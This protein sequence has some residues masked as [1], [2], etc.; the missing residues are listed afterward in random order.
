MGTMMMYILTIKSIRKDTILTMKMKTM[1][2]NTMITLTK[3]LIIELKLNS[4]PE[5]WSFVHSGLLS[6]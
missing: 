1:M 4:D 6:I 5:V 2:T 3:T